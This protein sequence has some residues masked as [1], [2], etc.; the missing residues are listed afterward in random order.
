MD[1]K[2]LKLDL[3]S[4]PK[5]ILPS[6]LRLKELSQMPIGCP[7]ENCRELVSP[8]D[9]LDHLRGYHRLHTPGDSYFHLAFEAERCLL[10]FDPS[11]LPC[12]KTIC[13]GVL[14]FGG[15]RKDVGALPGI[16]GIC[17]PNRLP[18]NIG[19]D[20]L[21]NFLPVMILVRKCTFLDWSLLDRNK[22]SDEDVAPTW[23]HPEWSDPEGKGYQDRK[24]R[25]RSKCRG[26][27]ENGEPTR[28]SKEPKSDDLPEKVESSQ[29]EH[30]DS[31]EDH[32]LTDIGDLT[33]YVIWTQGAPCIRP[34]HVSMTAFD[35]VLSEGRSALRRVANTGRV[36][37]EICGKELP[38][39]RNCMTLS[40]REIDSLC[41]TGYHVQLEMILYENPQEQT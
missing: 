21:H 32:E 17:R 38:K 1:L 9:L 37:P 4:T 7:L 26:R 35:R 18:R 13:L 16:R 15:K 19:L 22:K 20:P 30:P 40:Q 28:S 29:L 2:P 11:Q 8:L 36:Y 3:P 23:K 34:L 10:T 6:G 14:L 25:Y 12:R 24:R 41:G 27:A 31:A 39:D 5:T 33:M